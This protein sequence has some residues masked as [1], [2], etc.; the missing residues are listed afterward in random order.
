MKSEI[1]LALANSLYRE[2]KYAEALRI[3]ME[4]QRLRGLDIYKLNINNCER[5]LNIRCKRKICVISAVILGLNKGGGG[6]ATAMTNLAVAL[7]K[8]GNNVTLLYTQHPSYE[9]GSYNIWVEKFK[10][11]FGINFVGLDQDK[12]NHF[13][14]HEMKRSY[15]VCKYLESYEYDFVIFPDYLGLAYFTCMGKKMGLI[16]K[17]TKIIINLHGNSRLSFQR[18]FKPR[19]TSRDLI[20]CEM[21]KECVANADAI[22]SPSQ[23]YLDFWRRYSGTDVYGVVVPNINYPGLVDLILSSDIESS[24]SIP[25][26]LSDNEF[27][28]YF[29]FSRLERRKGLDIF[30]DFARRNKKIKSYYWFYGN[31]T[32]IDGITS[33]EYIGRRLK[34]KEIK[35]SVI[36]NKTFTEFSNH[37]KAVNGLFVYPTLWE[38]SPCTIVEVAQN[39]IRTVSSDIPGIIEMLDDNSRKACLFK[40]G[41]LNDL[42]NKINNSENNGD[43]LVPKM[44]YNEN[45]CVELWTKTIDNVERLDNKSFKKSY[46]SDDISVIIPTIGRVSTLR[47][48][49]DGFSKQTVRPGEIIIV[50]DGISSLKDLISLCSEYNVKL[51]EPGRVYKGK[52]CNIAVEKSVGSLLLFFDDDDIPEA[53]YLSYMLNAANLGNYDLISSFQ[54]VVESEKINLC[55]NENRDIMPDYIS[56][57]LGGKNITINLLGN[58]LAKGCFLITRDAFI[59]AGGYQKDDEALPCVDYR[60]FIKCMLNNISIGLIPKPIYVYRK[61]SENSLFAMSNSPSAL[62]Q[63]KQDLAALFSDIIN[64]DVHELLEYVIENHGNPKYAVDI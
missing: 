26:V 62:Y 50:Y 54:A 47:S 34:G 29:F 22:V 31:S 8:Q 21:E 14:T 52:A 25:S 36:N 46:R 51:M 38:N 12:K 6:I 5:K 32:K 41:N 2:K 17:K 3:Y 28:Q 43:D 45:E 57:A 63:A 10:S 13:G 23:D 42:I 60:F 1:S 24:V 56:M 55:I 59:R 61:N 30:I 4:L 53:A 27:K 49:L 39:N 7:A 48:T 64:L 40:T 35:Y 58:Y 11:D 37:I 15:F 16:S 18:G 9:S 19:K 44:R 33:E 20:T